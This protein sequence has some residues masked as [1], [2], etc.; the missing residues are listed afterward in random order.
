M[1]AGTVRE[2][3]TSRG[4]RGILLLAFVL[5]GAFTR[6]QE[7]SSRTAKTDVFSQ[8]RAAQPIP[9]AL[10]E[11]SLVVPAGTQ[12]AV[13]IT[14]E[15]SSKR[16]ADVEATVASDVTLQGT[17]LVQRGERVQLSLG[18]DGPGRLSVG[19]VA[20]LYVEGVRTLQGV[21]LPLSG[22]V[23]EDAGPGCAMEG[24]AFVVLVPWIKG[25][26]AKI[27]AG[28]LTGARVEERIEIA[29]GEARSAST[30]LLAERRN[31]TRNDHRAKIFVYMLPDV[32]PT[33]WSGWRTL[34]ID[35]QKAAHL[36]PGEW[37]CLSLAEGEH[38][39]EFQK[40]RFDFA[41]EKDGTYYL[42]LISA[43]NYVDIWTTPGFQLEGK[44]LKFSPGTSKPFKTEC[45]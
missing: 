40:N 35:S 22:M 37:L 19:A 5:A 44:T 30:S 29:E 38:A 8:K 15:I 3:R 31:A 1:T 17:V 2:Q 26:H 34:K 41:V 7:S 13:L 21:T 24:C 39:L 25:P 12:V 23:R 32:S 45:W 27:L 28:T 43:G 11:D 10:R 6:A 42:R 4:C 20:T 36:A 18:I 16:R 33:S 14:K 9:V